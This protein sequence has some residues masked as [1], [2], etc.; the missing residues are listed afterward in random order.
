MNKRD[1]V[2]AIAASIGTKQV[3]VEE[4]YDS[5]LPYWAEADRSNQW[6]P[7]LTNVRIGAVIRASA[8]IIEA[9]ARAA[10]KAHPHR[11]NWRSVECVRCATTSGDSF[12]TS[13]PQRGGYASWEY[14]PIVQSVVIVGDDLL[15]ATYKVGQGSDAQSITVHA[16]KGHFFSG[17]ALGV[18]V[19]RLRDGMDYHPTAGDYMASDF[20]RRVIRGMAENKRRRIAARKAAKLAAV[21]AKA[22]AERAARIAAIFQ[23]DLATTRVT[24]LDSRKA[25]NCIEGSL[26]FAERKLGLS[27]EEVLAGGYLFSVP[28]SKVIAVANGQTEQA[29][30]AVRVAWQR[31]TTV[32]I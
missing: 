20:G 22:D 21:K 7:Q 25:G 27:R 23:R 10:R 30:R 13:V 28:A 16:P 15:S 29:M 24:L 17:D 8:E 18:V 26:A 14:T 31:E 3:R 11:S 1:T 6:T 19:Y 32:S 9:A 5:L 4:M 2:R 12:T